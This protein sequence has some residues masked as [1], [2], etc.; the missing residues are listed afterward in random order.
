MF[1]LIEVLA[2][3][4]LEEDFQHDRRKLCSHINILFKS[5]NSTYKVCASSRNSHTAYIQEDLL[6]VPEGGKPRLLFITKDLD[7]IFSNYLLMRPSSRTSL[8]WGESTTYMED[9]TTPVMLCLIRHSYTGRGPYR[10][11]NVLTSTTRT[12]VSLPRWLVQRRVTCL[13]ISFVPPYR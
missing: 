10:K 1:G 2:D 4:K 8:G 13:G 6:S 7:D 11:L 12:M 9:C 3:N 5:N